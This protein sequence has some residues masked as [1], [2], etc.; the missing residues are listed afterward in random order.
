[1]MFEESEITSR[2]GSLIDEDPEAQNAFLPFI[3]MDELFEKLKLIDYD[4]DF[5]KQCKLRPINRYEF[6]AY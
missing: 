1:M 4:K 2:T 6:P 5:T 3:Q